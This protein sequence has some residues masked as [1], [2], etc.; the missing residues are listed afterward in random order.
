LP[1]HYEPYESPVKNLIYPTR[2]SN[3][4]AKVY[5]VPGNPY[6][7][8]ASAEYPCVLSTYRLTEHH[9]SGSMSRWVPWLSAL[10]P[11]LFVEISPEHAEEI[12]VKNLDVVAVST[13]RAAVHAKA[14]VTRRVR[15]FL[16]GVGDARKTVH[17]VGMPWHWGY[18]GL[19]T[20]DVVNDLSALVGDPNVTIHEAKVFV[21]RV[22]R[23]EERVRRL[24]SEGRP[25]SP[26]GDEGPQ[27][28]EL[29]PLLEKD[30]IKVPIP[31]IQP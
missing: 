7:P 12:G 30:E 31:P 29:P 5:D 1:A 10:Q 25:D 13:P 2:S 17:H 26:R 11:E 24:Q 27:G 6:S 19:V 4:V 15:P 22:D 9:L 16:I 18:K 21:C 28:I 20:G 23:P 8:P 3:P 14:L